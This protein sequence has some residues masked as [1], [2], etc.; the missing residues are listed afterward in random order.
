MKSLPKPGQI[1]EWNSLDHS[2]EYIELVISVDRDDGRVHTI[3]L[4]RDGRPA[5][6]YSLYNNRSD[7]WH[8]LI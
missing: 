8:R 1:W 4:L 5:S 6:W 3:S 7:D 2:N